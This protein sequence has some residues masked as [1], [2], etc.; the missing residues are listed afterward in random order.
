[1][2]L[3]RDRVARFVTRRKQQLLLPILRHL[4]PEAISRNTKFDLDASKNRAL[5]LQLRGARD[6]CWAEADVDKPLVTIRIPTYDRGQIVVD[7]A[8]R[9]AL[10]QTYSK[11]EVL[12]IGDGATEETIRA[13]GSVTD[14]RVRFV[15]LPRCEYP[16]DPERRWMV[17]GHGPMNHALHIAKGSW[18]APLDDDDEFTPDHVE[19]LLKAAIARRLEFVYAKTAI[20]QPDG[21]WS[22]L[23]SWPPAHGGF[24]HGA[25]LYSARLNFF[26]YDAD[27]WRDHYPA[28]WNLWRHMIAAGVRFG[29]VDHIVYRYY[30][31]RHVLTASGTGT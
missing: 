31:A 30:P 2:R 6:V 22:S 26:E 16:A 27:S 5:L 14:P 13:V 7:R 17:V 24:T 12:V 8:I 4:T 10:L 3:T 23:G 28:D 9:S 11:V 21:S 15:N 25:V 18:I 20:L 19:V 29:F 1:M